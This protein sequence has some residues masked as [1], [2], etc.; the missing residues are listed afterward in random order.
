MLNRLPVIVKKNIRI[1]ACSL[2][3]HLQGNVKARE[4]ERLKILEAKMQVPLQIIKRDVL[5]IVLMIRS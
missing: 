4:Q 1:P 2:A 5:L 3:L